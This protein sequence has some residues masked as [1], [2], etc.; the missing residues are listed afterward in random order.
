MSDQP[1]NLFGWDLLYNSVESDIRNNQDVLVCLVHLVLISNGFKCIG[2][3]DSKILDG[4]EN[5]SESLPKGW[6]DGYALRY[7]YQGRLYNLKGTA[8]DDGI[9]INLVRVDERTVSMIQLNT[10][11]VAQRT[12]TLIQMIPE[13]TSLVEV[14]KKQLIDKVATSTKTKDSGNQTQPET[15]KPM[16]SIGIN[17]LQETPRTPTYPYMPNVSPLNVGSADLHPLGINPLGVPRIPV[18]PGGGGMLFVPPGIRGPPD[19]NMGIP[20][21]SLPPGAR[22]DPFRPPDVDRFPRR[23]NDPDNDEMPPPGFDDMFM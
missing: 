12:G 10:R 11:S 20:G 16:S 2:I 5:K 18:F 23:P 8:L 17:P 6:N 4:T 3:G 15:T 9:I 13:C 1:S 21:G 7:I 22:F 19:I 14:V